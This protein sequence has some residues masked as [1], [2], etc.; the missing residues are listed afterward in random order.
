MKISK[1]KSIENQ[2]NLIR[3]KGISNLQAQM[4]YAK[5]K[6]MVHKQTQIFTIENLKIKRKEVLPHNLEESQVKEEQ[7]P[8]QWTSDSV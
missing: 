3:P 8:W 2:M 1:P 6:H 4:P 7:Q 5:P